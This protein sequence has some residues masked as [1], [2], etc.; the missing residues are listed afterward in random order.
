LP[1]NEI[2]GVAN[3]DAQEGE[4]GYILNKPFGLVH[5]VFFPKAELMIDPSNGSTVFGSPNV[6][7][8]GVV[9]DVVWNGVGYKCLTTDPG[10]GITA[11][12]YEGGYENAPFE[13]HFEQGVL[14]ITAK[15]GSTNPTLEIYEDYVKKLDSEFLPESG[16]TAGT[17][18]AYVNETYYVPIFTVDETGRVTK[19]RQTVIYDAGIMGN[20]GLMPY[21][22]YT[23]VVNGKH[24]GKTAVT[25]S[26][27]ETKTIPL[28]A[29]STD[30]TYVTGTGNVYFPKIYGVYIYTFTPNSPTAKRWVQIP[31]QYLE[32]VA[33]SDGMA[34]TVTVYA[35]FPKEYES[36]FSSGDS[37]PVV[38]FYEAI[39]GQS[40][41]GM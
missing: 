39:Y 31:P 40:S 9:H 30:Y 26:V 6:P 35:T 36:Y 3:C 34:S 2:G 20:S 27:G 1:L 5:E 15:D 11:F 23:H 24:V 28:Y 16:V 41:S 22:T 14:F 8:L 4:P 25:L 10:N 7:T 18:G 19:A 33:S 37:A 17:Y 12:V 21:D 32:Y 38:I 29:C 13:I